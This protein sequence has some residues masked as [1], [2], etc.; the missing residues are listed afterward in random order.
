MSPEQEPVDRSKDLER[1]I[2][3][4]R[5]MNLKTDEP[6]ERRCPHCGATIEKDFKICPECGKDIED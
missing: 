1:I 5:N 4:L 3:A 6:P 2:T